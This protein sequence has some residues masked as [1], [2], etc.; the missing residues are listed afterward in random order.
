MLNVAYLLPFIH[1]CFSIGKICGVA[2]YTHIWWHFPL[3]S[4]GATSKGLDHHRRLAFFASRHPGGFIHNRIQRLLTIYDSQREQV[5]T[6]KDALSF[7]STPHSVEI[8]SPTRP[9]VVIEATRQELVE[10]LPPVLILHLKRFHYDTGVGDV[11][12][13]GKHVTFGP[14]LE[15]GPGE[16]HCPGRPHHELTQPAELLSP[17]RRTSHP[18]K[19]Q[20][21]AGEH[22]GT[23]CDC[24][25]C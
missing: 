1:Y 21:F 25:G 14:D 24:S 9:G 16:L 7:I 3:D 17:T 20:L 23:Q 6:I 11:V 18:V 4:Q 15:I 5:N 19:Y 8:S 2:D 12:K 10:L 22:A 13:I